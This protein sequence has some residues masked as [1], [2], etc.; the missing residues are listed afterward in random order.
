MKH[1]NTLKYNLR[2]FFFFFFFYMSN[3]SLSHHHFLAFSLL[4]PPPSLFLIHTQTNIYLWIMLHFHS[5]HNSLHSWWGSDPPSPLFHQAWHDWTRVKDKPEPQLA[6][7]FYSPG[8]KKLSRCIERMMMSDGHLAVAVTG[9][10]L[11]RPVWPPAACTF[12]GVI[13]HLDLI[14]T[15]RDW[16]HLSTN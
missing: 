4:F 6:A 14:R 12:T 15:Q 11:L 3:L 1:T 5:I 9:D 16:I 10:S 7:L 2:I 13:G 8:T